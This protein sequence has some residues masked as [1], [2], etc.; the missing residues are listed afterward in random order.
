M[1]TIHFSRLP[2]THQHVLQMVS[3]GIILRR[4][5]SR[6]DRKTKTRAQATSHIASEH[7]FISQLEDQEVAS[8]IGEICSIQDIEKFRQWLIDDR[9]YESR[10]RLCRFIADV[11]ALEET[12]FMDIVN[13]IKSITSLPEDIVRDE[14]YKYFPQTGLG[15]IYVTG[16]LTLLKKLKENNLKLKSAIIAPSRNNPIIRWEQFE[17]SLVA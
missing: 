6:K 2:Q 12:P 16:A 4:K 8:S 10:L 9:I 7:I 1:E 14:V 13:H 5:P 17:S 3:K 15:A 11:L